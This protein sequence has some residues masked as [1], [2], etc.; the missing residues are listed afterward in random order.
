MEC[1]SRLV[2]THESHVASQYNLFPERTAFPGTAAVRKRKSTNVSPLLVVVLDD[3]GHSPIAGAAA[4]SLREPTWSDEANP[5][6][7]RWCLRGP[8]QWA[9]VLD[10]FAILIGGGDITVGEGGPV[11]N[12]ERLYVWRVGFVGTPPYRSRDRAT[13]RERKLRGP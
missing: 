5:A 8:L 6:L 3:L 11:G 2:D 13:G 7:E 10:W 12:N 9:G 1:L 4:A